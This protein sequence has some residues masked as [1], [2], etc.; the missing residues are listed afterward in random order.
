MDIDEYISNR[1]K[2]IRFDYVKFVLLN[3]LYSLDFTKQICTTLYYV[4]FN[5]YGV[6]TFMMFFKLNDNYYCCI[7]DRKNT[8]YRVIQCKC[9]I[10][11]YN[12]TIL[13]GI[14]QNDVFIVY[15]VIYLCGKNTCSINI[16]EKL[17]Y[18]KKLF[19]STNIYFPEMYTCNLLDKY[20][21]KE[22]ASMQSIVKINGLIFIPSI[23]Y[24]GSRY[25]ILTNITR[26]NNAIIQVDKRDCTTCSSDNQKIKF[27]FVMEKTEMPDVFNLLLLSKLKIN[28]CITIK[29]K[30]YNI[31]YIKTINDSHYWANIFEQYKRIIVACIYDIN[32]G[33]WI[34]LKEII[35]E[36]PSY[37]ACV[38]SKINSYRQNDTVIKKNM[39]ISS[40]I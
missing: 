26:I 34:P 21:S 28:D 2:N 33:R 11:I 29:L 32:I 25:I 8:Q 18:A 17:T 1:K 5:S 30:K 9:D 38:D 20:I 16:H 14:Y 40:N 36:L 27:N 3:D 12:G 15:D 10:S 4:A 6:P 23:S 31:A 39:L 35:N 22:H 13:S 37:I 7:V 24:H 19:N